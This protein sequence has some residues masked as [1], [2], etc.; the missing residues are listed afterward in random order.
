LFSSLTSDADVDKQIKAA[1]SAFGALKNVITYISLDLRVKRR[2][3]IA[4][5]LSIL[6]CGSEAWCLREDL[7][8]RL[9]SFHNRCVR[10][11]CRIIMAHTIKHRITSKILIERH[12][13][14]SFDSEYNRRLVRWAGHA[15]P[16]LLNRMPRKLLTGWV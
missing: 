2:I 15:A 12:G 9:R 6:L 14:G 11:M 13:V 16:M 5:V 4:L 8:N 7:F 10:S 1:T 3:Y